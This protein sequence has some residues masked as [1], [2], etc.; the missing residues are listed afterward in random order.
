M[1]FPVR[2]DVSDFYAR[3]V[4]V[5]APGWVLTALLTFLWDE[6]SKQHVKRH[7]ESYY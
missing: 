4:V 7:L 5:R 2:L 3:L 6:L 1:D